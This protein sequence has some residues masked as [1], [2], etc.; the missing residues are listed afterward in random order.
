MRRFVAMMIG[1]A[2]AAC[3]PENGGGPP[4][5]TLSGEESR[6]ILPAFSPDGSRL[7]YWSPSDEIPGQWEL[8]VANADLSAPAKLGVT[9]LLVGASEPPL[10]S[11]D[12]S[13][14]A[15]TSSQFGTADVV[16]VPAAGGEVQ[17]LTRLPGLA[18][19][20]AWYPD[21][22]RIAVGVTQDKLFTVQVIS[23]TSGATVPLI[24]GESRTYVG[25]PSPDGSHIA[26][27]VIEGARTTL[28]LADSVGGNRRQLTTEGFE[29]TSTNIVQ[30]SPDGRE[31][32]Y[33]SRRTGTTDIWVIPIDGGPARQLTRDVRNDFGETWSPDGKW[34]SFNS[35]RGRQ[36]DV[37]V[38]PAAGGT[39]LRVTDNP[40][41][42]I[43]PPAWRPTSTEL[44][45]SER[46]YKASY[47]IRDLA[48]GSERQL[49]PDSLQVG[50]FNLSPDGKWIDYVVDRGGGTNDLVVAPLDGSTAPRVLFS[51]NGYVNAARW[52]PDG[53][54]ILFRSDRGGSWDPWVVNVA[55]GEAR[56]VVDWSTQEVDAAWSGDGTAVLFT[57]DSGSTL[58]DLWRA[59]A[60]GGA[61]T[62]L[63]TSG[64]LNGDILTR[65]GL[66]A[67]VVR[68][69]GSGGRLSLARVRPDG[70][71]QTIWDRTNVLGSGA[72]T[73]A[74]DSIITWVQQDDGTLRSM[75]LATDG[76]GGRVLLRANEAPGAV[77]EDGRW[78]SYSLRA[79][80]GNDLGV[81][82][83]ASGATKRITTTPENEGGEEFTPDGKS[84]VFRRVVVTQRLRKADLSGL[85]SPPK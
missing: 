69:I 11:P 18:I 4:I 57:S 25:N 64:A 16:V 9:S 41:Y 42:E 45:Y 70:R 82:D 63:T 39:E 34:I 48:D 29:N 66:P 79:D 12:G 61:P 30:W 55:S 51:G 81:L 26:Y 6:H 85:L 13:R 62:R 58:L 21:G 76:S 60:T 14:I 28:W 59:P 24:P 53:S 84:L 5:T 46:D 56:Q 77:S 83:L 2:L 68:T 15:T 37:W 17:R 22:D 72:L 7:A 8:W 50:W 23:V 32:A 47:W 1:V 67:I 33:Q 49:T 78:L 73:P 74:G 65:R 19:A 10:W 3:T 54:Q 52:S 40:E 20:L 71:L 75:I 80:G 43:F 31:I 35:D 38:V 44:V 27:F 36:S